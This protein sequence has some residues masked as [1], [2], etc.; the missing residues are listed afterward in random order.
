MT[1]P[2][3]GAA[4]AEVFLNLATLGAQ[5]LE[6]CDGYRAQ[7]QE[8]GYASGVVDQMVAD[9]HSMLMRLLLSGTKP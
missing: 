6:A 8:R 3:D 1:E 9:Y 4:L 2:I 7:A 5:V